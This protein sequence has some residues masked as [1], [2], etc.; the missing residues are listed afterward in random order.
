MQCT[1]V[2][3]TCVVRLVDDAD[4]VVQVVVVAGVDV[5][6]VGGQEGDFMAIVEVDAI[7]IKEASIL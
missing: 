4:S 6:V 7:G 2:H 1:G 5:G 3:C